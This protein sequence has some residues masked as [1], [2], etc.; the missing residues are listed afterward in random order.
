[1]NLRTLDSNPAA[2]PPQGTHPSRLLIAASG[3]GGHLFPALA[4][5]DQLRAEQ[6]SVEWLGVS[7]RLETQLVPEDYPLRVISVEGFQSKDLRALWVFLKFLVS[8]WRTR[9]ILQQGQFKGVLTTGG[10][11]AAPA[12]IAA[13]TLG[14]PSILHESNAI[15]GKVTRSLSRWCTVVALGFE[16]AAQYLPQAKTTRWVGTPV[17]SQF[18]SPQP[19]DLP[20][21]ETAPVIVVAGGSQGAVGLNRKVRACLEPWLEAGAWIVHLTGDRDPDAHSYTHPHY[22]EFSFFE[23]MAG[24]LQ[25]AN[26]AISR[27]GAGTLTELAVTG[28]PAILI[29]Y[30]Y[31]AED[32]QAFNAKVYVEAGAGVM[33][34]EADLNPA[35][36]EALV[37]DWLAH[38]QSLERMAAQ[39]RQ[40]AVPNSTEQ[41]VAMVRQYCA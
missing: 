17:R 22:L 23:N 14:L 38:P 41:V 10:Y 33:F 35:D 36:L 9:R 31:A 5:A 11:I 8:I 12:I 6:V 1:M 4:I 24:L 40:V 37:L 15:P 16:R 39:A 13:R 21:P 20:I 30:P 27:S 34:R 25:R 29:P 3:T 26:L 19:L 32:H 18:Q 28:T 2:C 7:D